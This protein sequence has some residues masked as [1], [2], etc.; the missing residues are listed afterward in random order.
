MMTKGSCI[1]SGDHRVL[2]ETVFRAARKG[3][4]TKPSHSPM[5]STPA[6]EG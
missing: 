1:A 5:H 4:E 2:S 3:P 6:E